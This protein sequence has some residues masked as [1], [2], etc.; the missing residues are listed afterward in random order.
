MR[1]DA[2][3][4][5]R[6]GPGSVTWKVNRE[7]VVVAGWGRALLL[8]FSHP[9]IAAG[10]ADH[11]SFSTGL[12]SGFHRLHLTIRAMLSLTFGAERQAIAAAA[13]I[14][15]IHDRVFG[16]LGFSA[17]RFGPDTPYSAHQPDL[18]RWV[19]ATLLESIPLTYE[20]LV[21]PLTAAERDRYC[22]EAAIMEPLLDIPAGSLPRRIADLHAY[23]GEMLQSGS[24]A[25]SEASRTLAGQVLHPPLAPVLWPVFR[26][27][28]LMTIG[29]LPHSIRE[30]YGFPWGRA[31]DRALMR[32][33]SVVRTFR[34]TL[35][36]AMREW[37]AVRAA[38][39]R[40]GPDS[41]GPPAVQARVP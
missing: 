7:A 23:M 14:N 38:E 36:A 4:L 8:Q 18:L 6:P 33:V 17:G 21:G 39:R 41:P 11:S 3:G 31:E 16:E 10:V 35:P 20:L 40:A 12:F 26:P 27:I 9:L 1:L 22:E 25:V 24:I 30:A 28:R 13:G 37:P 15:T 5:K 19:H 2:S 34:A 32:W 29:L